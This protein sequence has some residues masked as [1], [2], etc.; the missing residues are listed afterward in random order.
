MFYC[1]IFSARAYPQVDYGDYDPNAEDEEE[2]EPEGPPP[3]FSGGPDTIK[4][5]LGE[6]A[7][8][9]CSI[10]KPSKLVILIFPIKKVCI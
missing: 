5:R 7:E 1:F 6:T 4:V 2:E 10:T 9:P 3:V 8:I